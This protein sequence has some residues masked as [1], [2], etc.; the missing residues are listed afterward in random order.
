MDKLF[1]CF[2]QY[3]YWSLKALRQHLQQPEAYLKETLERVAILHRSGSFSAHYSLKQENQMGN[4]VDPGQ[5]MAPEA[6]PGSAGD[7]EDDL[8]EDGDTA[9]ENA[10]WV[11][12]RPEGKNAY[13]L[14]F[15]EGNGK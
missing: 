5:T 2:N 13:N 10:L 6:A 3:K 7:F 4:Y 9:F 11:D 1:T 12:K 15:S 14:A 8:D